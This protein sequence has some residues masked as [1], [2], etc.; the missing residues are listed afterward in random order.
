MHNVGAA[1]TGFHC[2]VFS[3]ETMELVP[4]GGRLST[5]LFDLSMT[6]VTH[7]KVPES[8]LHPDCVLSEWYGAGGWVDDFATRKVLVQRSNGGCWTGFQMSPAQ[9]QSVFLNASL[10]GG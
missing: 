10:G 2:P 5:V 3:V 4:A 8:G 6:D 1:P 7:T 9:T